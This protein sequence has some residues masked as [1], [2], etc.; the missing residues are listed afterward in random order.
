LQAIREA[1][2]FHEKCN[3]RLEVFEKK[4]YGSLMYVR[5][6]QSTG[7]SLWIPD[8]RGQNGNCD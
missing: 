2:T 6:A 1:I 5:N 7:K 3:G 4:S 8:C